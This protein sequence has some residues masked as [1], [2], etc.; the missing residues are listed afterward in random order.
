MNIGLTIYYILIAWH[1]VGIAILCAICDIDK[2]S[3]VSRSSGLTF[4]NPYFIKRNGSVNWF[5]AVIIALFYN[6]LA[7]IPAICYWLYKLCTVGVK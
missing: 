3:A 7:P 4:M 6:I 5:G 2:Q 1:V